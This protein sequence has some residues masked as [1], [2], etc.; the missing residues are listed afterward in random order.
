MMPALSPT[1]HGP[2]EAGYLS[3]AGAVGAAAAAGGSGGGDGSSGVTSPMSPAGPG[4]G[5]IF[6][7]SPDTGG[8]VLE[9]VAAAERAAPLSPSGRSASVK[10]GGAAGLRW[11]AAAG[12]APAPSP[13]LPLLI[14]SPPPPPSPAS[15]H[16]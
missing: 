13:L 7:M 11:A 16:C 1:V 6:P 14:V 10:C 12:V 9:A 3:A 4:G 5:D 2:S 15:Q 8:G